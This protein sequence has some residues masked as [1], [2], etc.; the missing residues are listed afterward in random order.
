MDVLLNSCRLMKKSV[1]FFLVL[2]LSGCATYHFDTK[3]PWKLRSTH[4]VLYH[5]FRD[6]LQLVVE[7]AYSH[8][9]DNRG[10]DK[11]RICKVYVC[12]KSNN[13]RAHND[14]YVNPEYQ[15]VINDTTFLHFERRKVTYYNDYDDK[16]S[17]RFSFHFWYDNK[18]YR[19]KCSSMELSEKEE[20]KRLRKK[21]PLSGTI[22]I[23]PRLE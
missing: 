11:F 20:K 16:M 4:G 23:S 22:S 2:V 9:R 15:T 1:I 17:L 8:Y 19:A 7:Y 12:K 18:E 6:S 13:S 14:L 3:T 21:L 10:D 5:S